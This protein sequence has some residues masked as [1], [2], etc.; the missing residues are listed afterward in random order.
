MSTLKLL[1]SSPEGR[2]TIMR[3][4]SKGALYGGGAIWLAILAI[5]LL[6]R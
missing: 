4:V 5:T 6:T 2:E 1:A 3:N